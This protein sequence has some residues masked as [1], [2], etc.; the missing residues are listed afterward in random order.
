MSLE[1]QKDVF[2][3][4]TSADARWAEWIAWQIEEAGYSV[5]LQARDFRPGTNFV[6]E[7]GRAISN[8]KRTRAIF[9]PHYLNALYTQPEWAA[10]FKQ[11]PKGKQGILVLV[12][13]QECEF[14]G[15]LGQIIYVDL[16]EGDEGTASKILLTG[17]RHECA[18]P[19]MELTFPEGVQHTVSKQL[20]FPGD[21]QS[22]WNGT[23]PRD[24][25]FVWHEQVVQ[26]LHSTLNTK[27][28]VALTLSSAENDLCNVGMTETVV[29]YVYRCQNNYYAIFCMR[30]CFTKEIS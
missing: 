8:V 12:R 25:L 2:I 5:I 4:Y 28:Q 13:I 29:E 11:D 16:V 19:E 7:M 30:K 23:Y 20:S 9:S 27:H 15:L 6:S 17:V 10:A 26:A 14:T 3:G 22:I 1:V 18:K 24:N 21:F